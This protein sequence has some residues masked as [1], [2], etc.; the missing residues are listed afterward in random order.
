MQ[1][2][3]HT[4]ESYSAALMMGAGIVECDVTF[5][6]DLQL[7]CRHSQCDLHTTTNVV[8]IPEMNE[9]CTTPWAQGVTPSCCASDFTLEELKTLCA[10][11][12][13]S[14]SVNSTTAEGYVLGG[15]ADW[16]TD[17]YQ[18][19]C[20][21]VPTHK[22]SIALIGSNGGYFTPELKSPS[23][24]MPFMGSYTQQDYAQQMIDEYV[25]TDVPPS[26][27][28][29]QSFNVEDV[30]YWI[31]NTEYGSQ[32]VALDDNYDF[33]NDELDT[34]LD[35]LVSRGVSIVAPPMQRLV[36]PAPDSEYGMEMSYYA[37]ATKERGL[38]VITWTLERA[39]PGLSGFYWSTLEGQ[40]ELNEGDRYNI[41][42]ILAMDVEV[43]GVFSDWPATTTFFA[44]CMELSLRPSSSAAVVVEEQKSGGSRVQDVSTT[45]LFFAANALW[46][47]G[48]L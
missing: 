1:F 41:L 18:Y 42:Y 17:L 37:L 11:M 8:S 20:P 45:F 43:L 5:T 16:R 35:L 46:F 4:L 33:T 26:K 47:L 44:N 19:G 2:P 15:T 31:D 28:W 10:K 48:F 30:F 38:S 39:G 7:V 34:Y 25:L 13:S 12:D 6:K 27:V 36:E 14:G 29:P 9:K 24:E 23:V 3:E 40:V 21:K 22:E 32:A